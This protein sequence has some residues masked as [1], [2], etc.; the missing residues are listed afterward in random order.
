MKFDL[1]M[2]LPNNRATRSSHRTVVRTASSQQFYWYQILCQ[3]LLI[4]LLSAMLVLLSGCS[5][6]YS[7]LPAF[8]PIPFDD[9][10]NYSVGRFKTSYLAEQIDNYYRGQSPGP[11]GI[12]TFVN[13]DNLQDTST[14]GRMYGEQLMSELSNRGFDVVELRYA[15]A[16]QFIN[17]SGEFSMSRNPGFVRREQ[18]LGAVIVGTYVVSPLRVYVNA[19]LVDPSSA[20][21][22]SAGSV[23]MQKTDELARLL[24]SSSVG[25]TLE[26]IPVRHLSTS[27]VPLALSASPINQLYDLEESAGFNVARPAAPSVPN[28][29][30][31]AASFVE[32]KVAA[33]AAHKAKHAPAAAWHPKA[34][35]ASA[36]T[37]EA[38]SGEGHKE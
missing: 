1:D 31:P 5:R 27:V 6:R 23:E 9:A 19:R 37:K 28:W 35:S 25:A 4:M 38:A 16:L 18:N 15:D 11:I 14:F 29:G 21:V 34:E 10:Q 3:A 24:R 12:T 32:P 20:L 7:D 13:I 8:W 36:E 33:P 26:R 17:A 2:Q 22:L 30:T